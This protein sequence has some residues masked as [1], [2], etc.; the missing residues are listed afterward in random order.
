MLFMDPCVIA[1]STTINLMVVSIYVAVA[2]KQRTDYLNIPAS[3]Q[4]NNPIFMRQLT[5]I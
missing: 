5:S 3:V 2:A 1:G 4:K